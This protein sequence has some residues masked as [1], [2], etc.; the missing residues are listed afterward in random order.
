LNVG[1]TYPGIGQEE[2]MLL[3]S[4]ERKSNKG[5]S[6]IEL[7]VVMVILGLLAAVVGPRVYDHLARGRDQ[8]AKIQIKELEG[9]LQLYSLDIG[10]LPT[11]FE[12][13]DALVSNPGGIDTWKG[14]YL[15]KAVPRDP[16]D[17]PYVYRHPGM[18]SDFDLFSMGA[19]GLE[20]TEDDIASWQ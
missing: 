16:W 14:P 8:I 18:Y 7:I 13:L 10:R 6:L 20:G 3:K 2:H 11:T 12:G 4:E 17:R 19:D 5:F 9:A 1:W 15:S